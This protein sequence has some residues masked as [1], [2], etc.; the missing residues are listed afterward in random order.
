MHSDLSREATHNS[1]HPGFMYK[2]AICLHVHVP[3]VSRSLLHLM[4]L[5]PPGNFVCILF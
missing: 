3:Q 1:K 4:T 5:D 2:K